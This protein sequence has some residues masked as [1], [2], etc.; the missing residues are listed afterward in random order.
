MFR[1]LIT[2]TL[3]TVSV[4]L[5]VFGQEA[6]SADRVKTMLSDM[7]HRAYEHWPEARK[8]LQKTLP[9]TAQGLAKHLNDFA[10]SAGAAAGNI[11]LADASW[12]KTTISKKLLA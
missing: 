2:L 4:S 10:P 7:G 1:K 11:C 12:L 8:E 3:F 6:F 5:A 9:D